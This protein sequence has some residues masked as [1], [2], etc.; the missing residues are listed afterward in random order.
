MLH[1]SSVQLQHLVQDHLP[2]KLDLL[3][4]H[5]GGFGGYSLARTQGKLKYCFSVRLGRQFKGGNSRVY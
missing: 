5:G 3:L 1:H 2:D 4:G